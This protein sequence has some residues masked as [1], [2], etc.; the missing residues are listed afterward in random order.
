MRGNNGGGGE[1]KV[2]GVEGGGGQGVRWLGI[3]RRKR[4]GGTAMQA[5][6]ND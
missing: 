1:G 6:E 5:A 3:V 4:K 2:V